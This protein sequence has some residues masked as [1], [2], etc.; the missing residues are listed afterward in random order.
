MSLHFHLFKDFFCFFYLATPDAA[1]N[2]RI[3]CDIIWSNSLMILE[4]FRSTLLHH[5][6]NIQST[7]QIL[8]SSKSFDQ[9]RQYDGIHRDSIIYHAFINFNSLMNKVIF[10]TGINK[11]AISNI[12]GCETILLHFFESI[13]CLINLVHLPK[14]F[15]QYTISHCGRFYF[16]LDHVLECR[17]STINILKSYTSIN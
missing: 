10:N 4:G 11:A 7:I 3:E 2:K 6:K 15:Y 14:C 13:E 16:F 1:I 17:H 12:I 9:C 5:F 8:Y